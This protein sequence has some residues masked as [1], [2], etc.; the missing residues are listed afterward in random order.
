MITLKIWGLLLSFALPMIISPGPGNTVLAASGGKFGVRGSI[1]FWMG[2]EAGNLCWCLIYGFGLSQVFSRYPLVY[3]CLKWGGMLY[4]LYLAYGFFKSSSLTD[5]TDL[6]ALSFYDG[7]ISLSL[8]PKVHS[9]ILV[10]F[11]Q[12]LDPTLPLF[13]QVTQISIVFTVLGLACHFLWIYSGQMIFRKIQS[14]RAMQ[15]QGIGFGI[16]MIL[17]AIFVA[18]S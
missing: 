3:I 17:V 9:M 16:C 1:P 7:F 5:K 2:F 10:M 13:A 4:I 18:L 11:S 14:R 12:F 15:W 6:H 8:N